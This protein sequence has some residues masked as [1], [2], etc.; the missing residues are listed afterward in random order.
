MR[1]REDYAAA[2]IPMLPVVRTEAQVASSIIRYTWAMVATSLVLIPVA[3]MGWI[4][5]VGAAVLGGAFLFEAYLLRARVRAGSA[6]VTAVAMRL[7]HGS[8]TYLALLFLLVAIDPF[9]V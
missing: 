6:D 8:I 1:F 4:Y 3:H 7:F 9:V 2:G 5:G